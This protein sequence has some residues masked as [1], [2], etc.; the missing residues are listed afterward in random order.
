MTISLIHYKN[1]KMEDEKDMMRIKTVHSLLKEEEPGLD[2]STVSRDR[3]AYT[4]FD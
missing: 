1:F 3:E 4:V 2:Y